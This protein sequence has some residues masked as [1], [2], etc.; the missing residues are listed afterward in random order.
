MK[1]CCIFFF[2]LKNQ[3][4][5]FLNKQMKFYIDFQCQNITKR[6][7]E[8]RENAYLAMK[9]PSA[10][11]ALRWALDP[12]ANYCSLCSCDLALLHRQYMLKEIWGPPLTK[13]W[14]RYCSAHKKLQ[15]Y[16]I[17]KSH[18]VWNNNCDNKWDHIVCKLKRNV[19]LRVVYFVC[20]F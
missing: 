4:K 11:G 13:S 6:Y 12:P 10:S 2:F 20:N 9:N 5:F 18:A 16:W 7:S 14:I 8:N 19:F 17:R 3:K 15:K 1:I